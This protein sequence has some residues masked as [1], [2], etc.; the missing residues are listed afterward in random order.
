MMTRYHP[1]PHSGL[2]DTFMHSIVASLGWHAGTTIAHFLGGWLIV[3]A[4]IAGL[5]YLARHLRRGRRTARRG[6]RR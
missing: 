2:L 5:T 1:L 4:I 3:L 6:Y